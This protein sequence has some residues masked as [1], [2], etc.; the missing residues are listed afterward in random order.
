MT[1]E[2][3]VYGRGEASRLL[4]SGLTPIEKLA[5]G[6]LFGT[7]RY[8]KR[9]G[10]RTQLQ[11]TCRKFCVAGA[12]GNRYHSAIPTCYDFPQTRSLPVNSHSIVFPELRARRRSASAPISLPPWLS[13]E[14]TPYQFVLL[15]MCKRG[16]VS[17]P[18]ECRLS[19][20]CRILGHWFSLFRYAPFP[21]A[22]N[23]Q[24]CKLLTKSKKESRSWLFL[25]VV[26]LRL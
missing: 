17:A 25:P 18:W 10:T 4:Q 12:P 3:R 14:R 6:A 1:G 21:L 13:D 19:K 11:G 23:L 5:D 20:S 9:S 7:S 8:S 2:G 26:N 24:T 22:T 16:C 15:E